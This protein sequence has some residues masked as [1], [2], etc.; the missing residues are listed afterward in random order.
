MPG[1]ASVVRPTRVVQ[2]THCNVDDAPNATFSI[3][4]K[5]SSNL[6]VTR[7]VAFVGIDFCAVLVRFGRILG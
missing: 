2:T 5:D 6:F 1:R 4:L 3:F 7:Q